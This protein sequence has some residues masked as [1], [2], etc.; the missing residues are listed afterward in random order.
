MPPAPAQTLAR[1][2]AQLARVGRQLLR[3]PCAI[4]ATPATPDPICPPCREKIR[5]TSWGV[6]GLNLADQRVSVLWRERY[7]GPLTETIYRAKYRSDWGGAKTLGHCLGQLP[8][9]WTGQPPVVVAVPLAGGRLASRG[10]NQ[11]HWIGLAAAAQWGYSFQSRWLEKIRQTDR[12]ATLSRATRQQNLV[13]SFRASP[14][15]Q[16]KRILLIDDIMTTGATLKQAAQ[17]I[18][19]A[20][21]LVIGA[22]VIARVEDHQRQKNIRHVQRRSF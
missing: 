16:G 1:T 8:K 6:S 14:A 4:C 10:F 22:A 9:L 17:A 3:A 21:G 15:V 2:L 13:N 12:Q 18:R 7:G 5:Q 20:G 19:S 11:S